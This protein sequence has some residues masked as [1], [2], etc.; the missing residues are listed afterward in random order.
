MI[1]D[2]FVV[3][4][5]QP[6]I[7]SRIV[8]ERLGIKHSS[9]F[10]NTVRR[11]QGDFERLGKLHIHSR[12][13]VGKGGRPE[14]EAFLNERQLSLALAHS[15]GEGDKKD[16]KFELIQ[17]FAN[18][19]DHNIETKE[20]PRIEPSMREL[21]P[22][23]PEIAKIEPEVVEVEPVSTS[24][25][26][27]KFEFHGE[28]VRTVT[29]DNE[30]F[31]IAKDVF[32]R[33]DIAWRPPECLSL[34]PDAWKTTRK[35]RVEAGVR[36]VTVI[37]F[38]AASKIAFRSNKPYADDFTNK[39]AEAMENIV[40]TGMH[41]ERVGPSQPKDSNELIIMLAQANIERDQKMA[42]LERN[43]EVIQQETKQTQEETK[44]ELKRLEKELGEKP[45]S[46][47]QEKEAHVLQAL[48]ALGTRMGGEKS[49][50]AQIHLRFRSTFKIARYN[51]LPINRYEDAVKILRLWS[52][53]LD[54]QENRLQF[55][56]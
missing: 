48:R 39:A 45:I 36:E 32:D 37:N 25:D 55:E 34:I 16:A 33:L 52:K 13:R 21:A 38:K 12:K 53:E 43:Q 46:M 7:S 9:F 49:D 28:P 3:I 42:Q 10:S 54:I 50:Y 35:F 4:D 26:I 30:V 47:D 6:H 8:A 40:K 2:L 15:R 24:A 23:Q 29:I 14:I 11:Y 51:Q 44:K 19:K 27:S 31:F 5:G 20:A 17:E 56:S 1:R 18:F 41:I 22:I